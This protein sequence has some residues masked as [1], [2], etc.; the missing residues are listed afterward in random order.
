MQTKSVFNGNYIAHE[1]KGGKDKNLSPKEYLDTIRP[2]LG[3]MIID[4]KTQ[5]EW[6]IQL[7]M[8]VNFISSKD[9]DEIC[10]LHT[11]SNNIEIMMVNETDEIIDEIF[12]HFLQNY[13]KDLEE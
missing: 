5:G 9:S 8:S 6:K 11:R 12:E 1:R 13:Q 10:N 3:D 2:Y 4:Y 7:T